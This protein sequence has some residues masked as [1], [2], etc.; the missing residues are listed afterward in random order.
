MGS[1]CARPHNSPDGGWVE[2]VWLKPGGQMPLRKVSFVLSVDGLP[3]QVGAGIYDQTMTLED[4][5][6]I[7]EVSR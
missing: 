1:S 6:A 7:A 3:Y 5:I 4:V 2:Y